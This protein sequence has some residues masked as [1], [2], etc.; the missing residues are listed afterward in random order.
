LFE[1]VVE[2]YGLPM[3][4]ISDMQP[5]IIESVKNVMPSSILPVSLP[6]KCWQ[7]HGEGI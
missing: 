3:A 6:Q 2:M 4:V 5:T 1:K 7:F